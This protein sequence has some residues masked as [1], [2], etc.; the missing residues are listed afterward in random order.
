MFSCEDD[1]RFEE[2]MNEEEEEEEEEDIGDVD[3]SGTTFERRRSS[4][5]F[6][7]A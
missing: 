2:S 5:L 3:E 4:K 1:A 6:L 7:V